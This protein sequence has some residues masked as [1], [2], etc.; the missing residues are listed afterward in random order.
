MS[1]ALIKL[2]PLAVCGALLA[3][4]ASQSPEQ[5][6]DQGLTAPP[7]PVAVQA[8]VSPANAGDGKAPVASAAPVAPAPVLPP[9]LQQE[10]DAAAQLLMA[11]QKDKAL[12][13]YTAVQQAAPQHV[14]AWLNAALIKRE[15]KKLDEALALIESA[16]KQRPNEA[17][18]LTLKGVVL[19]EQGKIADAKAA[20]LAAIKADESYAPAHRNLAVLADLY[21]D[22]PVLALQHMERYAALVGDDKQVN[23]WVSELRR[24]AQAK[25]AGGGQ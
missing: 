2:V 9:A 5:T 8:V 20:Y 17:R 16:L 1:K 10:M 4:C 7:A 15:Q 13:K 22:D 6:P 21:L 18:A 19:R 24:R 11:G 3:G 25:P 12:A 23:S 14:S